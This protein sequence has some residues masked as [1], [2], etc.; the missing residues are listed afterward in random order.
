MD[1]DDYF[2]EPGTNLY[3]DPV[4]DIA[5]E[6]F[7]VTTLYPWQRLVIANIM[8]CASPENQSGSSFCPQVMTPVFCP[9]TDVPAAAEYRQH[10]HQNGKPAELPAEIPAVPGGILPAQTDNSP[11]PETVSGTIPIATHTGIQEVYN[12]SVSP[13][14]AAAGDTVT[15]ILNTGRQIVLLP[16]GA[17]KSLC[18]MV[19]ALLLS[20]PTLVIYPLLALM[21]DQMRRLE[22]AGIEAVVFQGQQTDE[23]RETNFRKIAAGTKIILANPEVLQSEP[24]VKRLAGCHIIHAAI[25]EAHCVSEW[26]DTFRPAYLTL[27]GILSRMNIPV[28]T[29]FT[30]TAS[31]PVLDRITEV[32][33][34]GSRP[35]L[36]KS[37]SD[38]QNIHY[39]VIYTGAKQKTALQLAMNRQRP[40][41]VFCGT[42]YR[43]EQTA[44]L[45]QEF[46]GK[47][48]V[49]FYH[50]GLSKEEKKD[51]EKWFFP[52]TNAVLCT[53]CAFGMG[54]DKS[55]IRTV[56]HLE[57]P[58]TVES[59]I[60][61]AGRGGRDGLPSQAILLWNIRDSVKAHRFPTGSRERILSDFAETT[62][63][64]RQVLLDA[65]QDT[66]AVCS[67]CDNCDRTAPA[68]ESARTAADIQYTWNFI[69]WNSGRFTRDQTATRLCAKLNRKQNTDIYEPGDFMDIIEQ[70]QMK[71]YIAVRGRTQ[72]KLVI[73]LFRHCP[74]M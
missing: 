8:E 54:V 56:I 48:N 3:P 73:P 28:I 45:F 46:L 6:K 13:L 52:R 60:Q 63:C 26:G 47:E 12:R 38:R 22:Q 50:A 2:E 62:G 61:E 36:M 53:T 58:P 59:Y 11:E 34:N 7:G 66:G 71:N 44:R 16:T 25:D 17:G 31:A 30:A 69:K 39:S 64:R 23:Q 15:D 9:A 19:P 18:F 43:S 37:T 20:R 32:L 74:V 40:V 24:L 4:A 1:N 49:R 21:S 27:G 55:N 68:P 42:R 57:P 67:G 33:F 65:L 51:V 5:R 14:H 29:A 41:L 72:K 70:L 10:P 35:Y